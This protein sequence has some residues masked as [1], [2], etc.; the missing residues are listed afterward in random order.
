MIFAITDGTVPLVTD[1]GGSKWTQRAGTAKPMR[2]ESSTSNKIEVIHATARV[3][4]YN[5]SDQEIASG[6]LVVLEYVNGR[7]TVIMASE[8]D[9]LS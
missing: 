5:V 1:H 3:T 6:S 7:L 2:F 4:V 8:C 9:D